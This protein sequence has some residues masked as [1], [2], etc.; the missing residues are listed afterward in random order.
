MERTITHML[1]TSTRLQVTPLR[2]LLS[3]AVPEVHVESA[4][5][6]ESIEGTCWISITPNHYEYWKRFEKAY[7][8]WKRLAHKAGA[9]SLIMEVPAFPTR[10]NLMNWLLDLLDVPQGGRSLFQLCVG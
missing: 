1:G 3:R 8:H 7:P 5:I 10:E 2:T 4:V 9:L 6:V